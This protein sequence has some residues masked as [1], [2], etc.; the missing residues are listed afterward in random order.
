[1][2]R[3]TSFCSFFPGSIFRCTAT[4]YDLV[5]AQVLLIVGGSHLPGNYRMIRVHVSSCCSSRAVSF[6]SDSSGGSSSSNRTA[7]E[8]TATFLSQV[9]HCLCVFYT[10]SAAACLTKASSSPLPHPPRARINQCPGSLNDPDT[11]A[12]CYK[13]LSGQRSGPS[14]AQRASEPRPGPELR[15]TSRAR[16]AFD[17]EL[18]VQGVRD[19]EA[20]ARANDLFKFREKEALARKRS[21]VE[22]GRRSTAGATA[23]TAVRVELATQLGLPS[24]ATFD[25]VRESWGV[26]RRIAN[27]YIKYLGTAVGKKQNT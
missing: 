6:N 1:M 26:P 8:C 7:I 2:V 24:T 19:S 27:A 18:K 4:A 22:R 5:A 10:P 15:L 20:E 14:A 9:L 23:S 16:P 17:E 25:E 21:E 11:N 3:S 12:S 13:G